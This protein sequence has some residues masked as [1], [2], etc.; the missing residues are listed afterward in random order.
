LLE[1]TL[2]DVLG[3]ARVARDGQRDAE[4]DPLEP[5]HEC[6]REVGIT[7]P[8]PGQQHPIGLLF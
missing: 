4:D 8:Q 2:R 6:D 7:R 3:G 1:G 5:A